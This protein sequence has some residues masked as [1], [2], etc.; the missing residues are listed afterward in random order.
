MKLKDLQ[1]FIP[2]W[3]IV[4]MLRENRMRNQEEAQRDDQYQ[5]A[6]RQT[7]SDLASVDEWAAQRDHLKGEGKDEEAKLY[8]QR[9]AEVAE[10]YIQR[11]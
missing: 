11:L 9:I 4:Y 6:L 2:V 1:A 3:Q 8:D 7:V 10:S 5:E